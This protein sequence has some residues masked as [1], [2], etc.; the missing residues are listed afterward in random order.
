MTTKKVASES[1]ATKPTMT[2]RE[3]LVVLLKRDG[4][5]SL[6]ELVAALGWLPHTTRA[7]LTGL[8]RTGHI[9]ESD[10]IEGVRRYRIVEAAA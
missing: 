6:D 10:K 1:P 8:K 4:G 7:A 5:A 2:K 3:Q 9:I